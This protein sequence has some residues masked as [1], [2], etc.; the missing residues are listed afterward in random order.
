MDYIYANIDA[1]IIDSG[2]VKF[3]SVSAEVDNNSGTPSVDVSLRDDTDL[4]FFFHNLKGDQG[5]SGSNG[6]NGAD[7][8]PGQPGPQGPQ[9]PQGLT[10]KGLD[11]DGTLPWAKITEKPEKFK[12]EDHLHDF[13]AHFCFCFFAF[14]FCDI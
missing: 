10:G 11:E 1:D 14:L 5:V 13:N 7:G 12:P 9:G 3:T 2:E 4:H 6:A 8:Q